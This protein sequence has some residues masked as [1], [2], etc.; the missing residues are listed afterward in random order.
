MFVAAVNSFASVFYEI[1]SLSSQDAMTLCSLVL[2]VFVLYSW[3]FGFATGWWSTVDRIWSIAPALYTVIFFS[4]HREN[5]RLLL[6]SI[7]SVAWATRLSLNF[8]RKGGFG[9]IEPTTEDYRWGIVRGWVQKSFPPPLVKISLELFHFAFVCTYQNILLF[10]LVVPVCL[11]AE[12]HP[13]KLIGMWDIVLGLSFL[14]LLLLEHKTDEEQ[15]A[16]QSRKHS[17][18]PSQRQAAG[19][20]FARGFCTNG[21]FRFS[22]HP[23]FF[24]EFSMW[25]V[26]S[27]F[28][29]VCRDYHALDDVFHWDFMGAFLLTLLFQGSTQLTEAISASK[30]PAYLD[31]QNSTSRLLP[32]FP[33]VSHK[34]APHPTSPSATPK[35]SKVKSQ[36]ARASS[37]SRRKPE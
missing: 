36:G 14:C 32:W 1:L 22:R 26:F 4:F 7:L 5:V 15:W 8:A 33:A 18:T 11:T 28:G 10:L 37:S 19:G 9:N 35:S 27:A 3:M 2:I 21:V 6:M 13:D 29:I 20:D 23:N 30:Y 24:A 12:A 34:T 17:M 31:Y 25:W 16:F